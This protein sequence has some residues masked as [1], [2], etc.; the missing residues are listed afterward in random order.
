ME[1]RLTISAEAVTRRRFLRLAAGAAAAATVGGCGEASDKPEATVA[2]KRGPGMGPPTVLRIAQLSHFVPAF[3]QW[4]DEDYAKRW[5][6]R[7]GIEVVVDHFPLEQLVTWAQAEVATQQGHDLFFFVTPAPAFEDDVIDHREVVEEV[8]ARVGKMVPLVERSVFNPKTKKWF[9]FSD[10]WSP[11]PVHYR[12]DVWDGIGI[13]P[14]S[15]DAVLEGAPK[16]KR[17]GHPL[18][19]GISRDF[20]SSVTLLSLMHAYGASVQD[21]A[22]NVAINRSETVEALKLMTSISR[23]G[24]T[25]DVFTWDASANNRFLAGGRGSLIVNAVSALR[26]IETQDEALASRVQLQPTPAGPAGRFG[27]YVTGTYVIWKFARNPEAAKQF[28][29]DLAVDYRDAFEKSSFYNLPSFPGS[30]PD[31]AGLVAQDPKYA[32]LADAASWSTNLGHPGYSSAAMDEALNQFI[33]PDMFAAAARGTLSAEEAA[34]RAEAQLQPI[35]AR[36]RER[37]KV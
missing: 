8:E 19:L 17:A 20:D 33:V 22:G 27:V 21:E 4:F 1:Q 10:A 30:V 9:G 36:W 26:A 15:W 28:L 25:E 13:K 29:V 24:M 18:G 5:A 12:S 32:V 37:G 34:Q 6:Q 11:G 7:T 31:L 16:V 2:T 23:A 3:D 35:F 14:D